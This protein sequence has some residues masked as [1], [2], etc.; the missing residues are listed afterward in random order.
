MTKLLDKICKVRDLVTS[1]DY[2]KL[3]FYNMQMLQLTDEIHRQVAKKTRDYS[4]ELDFTSQDLRELAKDI[5]SLLDKWETA[6]CP[7]KNIKKLLKEVDAD[8]KIDMDNFYKRVIPIMTARTGSIQAITE[9]L[10]IVE[11][12]ATFLYMVEEASN[13]KFALEYT[14]RF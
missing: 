14:E 10:N 1:K 6:M 5:H 4:Y 7:E 3:K 13:D 8:D 12:Y 2:G 9:F 11:F